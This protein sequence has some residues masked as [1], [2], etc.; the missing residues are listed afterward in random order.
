M[1]DL[2]IIGAGAAGITAA[3]YSS[4]RA[5]KTLV[6]SKDIGGQAATTPYIENYPGVDLVG[7]V[8]LMLKFKAQAEKFG[9]E[10]I[11]G[12]VASI[13]RE[14]DKF[15]VRT[16]DQV[17]DSRAII[18]AFGLTPLDLGV[19]GEEKFKGKGVVYCATCD[20]PLYKRKTVAVVGGGS[21]ALDAA[22]LLAKISNQVYLI[23]RRDQFRGEE[24]L[25]ER[26]K[27]NPKI[28][29]VLNSVVKEIKGD[30]VV[31]SVI[32]VDNKNNS[33][34]IKVDGVFVEIG[35]VVKSD[36]VRDLVKLNERKEVIVNGRCETSEPGIFAAGDV[37]D[38]DYKQI[39]ISAGEGAKAALTAYRYLQEKS[40][41]SYS[42]IDW[43]MQNK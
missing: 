11:F 27:E 6:I 23:H 34:E 19:P 8:E 30:R 36:F 9:A 4:R 28:E 21:S 24:I 26:V 32:V 10:F 39:V 3:I 25:V 41:K 13:K 33:R 35:H 18:L 38:I 22:L 40:G 1:Y 16:N 5:L 7:G 12:E 42:N 29:L 15:L 20:A 43:G 14:A 17:Y 31:E 37:A 2:I